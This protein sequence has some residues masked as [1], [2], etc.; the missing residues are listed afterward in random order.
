MRRLATLV[1][2]LAA[3][4]L[5]TC[6]LRAQ[7]D[8]RMPFRSPQSNMV[9]P[10]EMFSHLQPMFEIAQHVPANKRRF[11]EG[12]EIV[13][14]PTWQMHHK[15]L[16]AMR[17]DPGYLSAVIRD[18]R[19]SP[20]RRIA[21]Y[22]AF[23]VTTTNDVFNL[24]GHI[25]GEPVRE[26]REEAFKRAV[27]YL[28]VYLPKVNPGDLAEW[29]KLVVGPGGKKPPRPGD[30][31]DQLDPAPFAALLA[32]PEEIDQRQ[33]LWFFARC[34][35]IRRSFAKEVLESCRDT[36]RAIAAK[37][38]KDLRSSLFDLLTQLDPDPKRKH[39]EIDGP[40]SEA[41]AWLK[42]VE[43]ELLPP[44]RR[45]SSGLVDLY[46]SDD[47]DAVVR[48]GTALLESG[49]L[50]SSRNGKTAQGTSYRGVRIDQTPAPLDLLG[51]PVGTIV[52]A[53]NGAPVGDTARL[54]ALL[55]KL[56]PVTRSYV[57][58]YVDPQGGVGAIEFRRR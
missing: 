42:T 45:I 43:H 27:E 4:T 18:S 9:P 54:Y 15:A 17:Q 10:E 36:L 48:A 3:L 41:L 34:V 23:Y 29:N 44:I 14:D 49:Q 20:D 46:D 12:V 56:A 25:P 40:T 7:A 33:V 28:A 16:L 31:T 11:E 52:T 26:L 39:P 24:I 5:A 32:L 19:H 57:V 55:K 8:W 21:F 37:D 58:E 2:P 30:F 47:L 53:V 22:G 51:L 35:E 13:D 50:G 6:P 1:A 38:S